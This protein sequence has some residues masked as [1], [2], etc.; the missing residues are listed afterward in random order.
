MQGMGALRLLAVVPPDT[1]P[2]RWGPQLRA[3]RVCR[4]H[5]RYRPLRPLPVQRVLE[6]AQK[7]HRRQDPD[8]LVT[9]WEP[10]GTELLLLDEATKPIIELGFADG[11]R[12]LVGLSH[13]PGSPTYVDVWEASAPRPT[14]PGR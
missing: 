11:G 12:L 3:T 14:P 5:Q 6:R 7:V 8:H 13:L 9:L 10:G 2:Q 4:E 1:R